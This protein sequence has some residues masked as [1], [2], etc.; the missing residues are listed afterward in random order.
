ML[1]NYL[2][3]N[4]IKYTDC[5]HACDHKPKFRMVVASGGGRK[6]GGGRG[7]LG[8]LTLSVAFHFSGS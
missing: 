4:I 8:A 2:L 3:Y 1:C 7:P 6:M 5:R